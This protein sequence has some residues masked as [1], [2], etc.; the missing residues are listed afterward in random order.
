MCL[1]WPELNGSALYLLL[2]AVVSMGS[3]CSSQPA[4]AAFTYAYDD[5]VAYSW[6]DI[7]ATG[8]DLGLTDDGVVTFDI[9]FDFEFYGTPYNRVT[10]ADNGALKF[11]TSG[12]QWDNQALPTT[13]QTAL[14][15]PFWD[16]LNT[17][18]PQAAV[19]AQVQ[20]T[21]PYRK[22]IVQWNNVPYY[23]NT[24]GATFQVI[25]YEGSNNILFQYQDVVFGSALFDFGISATVGLQGSQTEA[26]EYSYNTPS[27]SDSLAIL[28][29]SQGQALRPAQVDNAVCR[30]GTGYSFHLSNKS[31]SSHDYTL[32]YNLTSGNGT[33]FGP[34]SVSVANGQNKDFEVYFKPDGIATDPLVAEITALGAGSEVLASEATL[35]QKT[36]ANGSWTGGATLPLPAIFPAVAAYGN[37][38]YQ[39]GG[40]DYD[41]NVVLAA[42]QRYDTVSDTWQEMTA[43]PTPLTGI[44][45]V[46]IGGSIF[47][48]GGSAA[49]SF[50]T[51]FTETLHIYNIGANSWSTGAPLP[52]KLAWASSVTDGAK[53]Y[54]LGGRNE[55]GAT[56]NKLYIYDPALNSW[57]TGA[58]MNEGMSF[59]SAAYI[60]GKIY[61][62]GGST[63]TGFTFSM[64]VYDV[65]TNTWS[66]GPDMPDPWNG[67][68][69][70]WAAYSDGVL[71]N[72]FFLVFGTRGDALTY[73]TKAVWYDAQAGSWE[74][75]P[76][77][78]RP[79]YGTE[80]A[81]VL[82]KLYRTG[83]L[84][85][86][87]YWTSNDLIPEYLDITICRPF[88]WPMFRAAT[89]NLGG[90]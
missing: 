52:A 63:S 48:P 1:K 36:W 74:S 24:G 38:L 25:L 75:L 58:D 27:L 69:T 21:A 5:A 23:Q 42:M 80:G 81:T 76:D 34:P 20:G 50:T 89:S 10:V 35:A 4:G 65:V 70:G 9:P 40:Y 51:P 39:I 37:Y 6:I 88:P 54:V 90:Q 64:E 49:Y 68:Y 83:G 22:V 62:A 26:I 30:R 67:T 86:D 28:W 7:S 32:S 71:E 11:N 18:Q 85:Y 15:A 56:S 66:A 57:S 59:A 79:V 72:R 77:L 47:V 53:L 73:D 82:G 16:D 8:T 46:T 87:G 45:A 33:V 60:E 14:I 17:G 78:N 31:G 44:H 61:F 29:T 19:Y 13:T 55:G 2:A 43:M 3:L 84:N 41:G 12:V